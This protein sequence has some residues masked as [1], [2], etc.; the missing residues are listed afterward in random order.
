MATLSWECRD[1][2]HRACDG[3]TVLHEPCECD[4]H[5][6]PAMVGAVALPSVQPP[7]REREPVPA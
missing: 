5:Q 6:D 3:R 2:E 7:Q 4:C 1:D